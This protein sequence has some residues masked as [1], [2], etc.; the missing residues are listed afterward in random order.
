MMI[1]SIACLKPYI[2]V[3]FVLRISFSGTRKKIGGLPD[4]PGFG[5]TSWF[6]PGFEW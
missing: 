4:S 3:I 2:V 1:S 6:G 5:R